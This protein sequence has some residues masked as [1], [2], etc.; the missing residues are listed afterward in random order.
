M[1]FK[2]LK[3]HEPLRRVQFEIFENLTRVNESQTERE[4]PYDYLLIMYMKKFTEEL[5][6]S[7]GR[8]EKNILKISENVHNP[9]ENVRKSSVYLRQPLLIFG[10]PR[11]SSGN[12]RKSSIVFGSFWVIFGN[13]RKPSTTF[14]NL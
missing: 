2:N 8:P 11:W 12:L 13:L 10:N 14:G 7:R 1:F 4:K 9:S 6:D 3:L 5:N